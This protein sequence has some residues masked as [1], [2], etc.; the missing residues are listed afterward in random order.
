MLDVENL[1]GGLFK[2]HEIKQG[3]FYDNPSFTFNIY[4]TE[5]VIKIS[6]KIQKNSVK[7]G[8]LCKY[9]IEGIVGSRERDV[10]DK[11]LNE[12]YKPF[13]VGKDI[14]RYGVDY[15]GKW[16]C[17][18]RDRLHRARPEEVFLSDKIIIQRISGGST[19]IVAT[20]DMDKYYTFAST[21]NLILKED[22]DYDIN[23]I[24]G[25]L[26]SNLINWYYSINYSNK[27]DLTV[28][29]SKTFLEE[30][31]IKITNKSD[32]KKLITLARELLFKFNL[33]F[34]HL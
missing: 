34:I 18:D 28:N 30:L 2:E 13:L 27:S 7:L 32:Q 25:L 1:V 4:G 15:K 16:I 24:L 21:N 10:S 3:Y 6:K 26:N 12:K 11:K 5:E 8:S 33:L 29:V 20:L 14:E 9:I 19:P 22:M 23:Y 31:P 17:Y